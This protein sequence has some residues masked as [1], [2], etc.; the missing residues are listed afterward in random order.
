MNLTLEQFCKSVKAVR[1]RKYEQFTACF[2]RKKQ[3]G[4]D[5][6]VY[7]CLDTLEVINPFTKKHKHRKYKS[8]ISG[9]SPDDAKK[10]AYM[11]IK[12]FN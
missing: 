7:V 3:I 6:Y 4:C 2:S 11:Y 8:F 12:S 10:Q 1:Y 9:F 5:Y